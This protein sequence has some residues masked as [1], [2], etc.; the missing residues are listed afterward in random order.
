MG[1]RAEVVP[2]AGWEP[3][4]YKLNH[5][6]NHFPIQPQDYYSFLCDDDAYEPGFF[7]KL[8]PARPVVIVSMK[9]GYRTPAVTNPLQAHPI[10][11]LAAAPE[12]RR[13]CC[14]GLEQMVLRGDILKTVTFENSHTA[15]GG[16]AECTGH[17]A[18]QCKAAEDNLITRFDVRAFHDAVLE[19]GAVT[20]PLLRE[21]I[22]RFVEE[23]KAPAR[24]AAAR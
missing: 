2:P 12:N 22:A 13:R 24:A 6:I 15:D 17:H 7:S 9:R 21:R 23:G 10:H 14:I 5:F 3:P 16:V 18:I 8:K 4:Y 11:S 20:L 1:L 19:N